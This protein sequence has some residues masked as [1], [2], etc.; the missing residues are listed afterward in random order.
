MESALRAAATVELTNAFTSVQGGLSIPPTLA[1]KMAGIAVDSL[2]VV[3][4]EAL[5][6]LGSDLIVGIAEDTEP[7]PAGVT[8]TMLRKWAQ[9]FCGEESVPEKKTST[10]KAKKKTTPKVEFASALLASESDDDDAW[11]VASMKS[12]TEADTKIGIMQAKDTEATGMS[13]PQNLAFSFS[14]HAGF[15]VGP[16]APV[17]EGSNYG[18][19]VSLTDW[20][21]KL[22]KHEHKSLKS[23]ISSNDSDGVRDHLLGLLRDYNENSMTSEATLL[24]LVHTVTEEMFTNDPK[25]KVAYYKA[26]LHKYR[27]RGLPLRDGFD[28]TLV[29]KQMKKTSEGG[30]GASA[31]EVTA[32]KT[33]LAA[34]KTTVNELKSEV[35]SLKT[36]IRELK[37]K[38]PNDGETKPCGY[39]GEVGHYARTCPKK[40]SD[41]AAKEADNAED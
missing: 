25:G 32:L 22:A 41:E 9:Y 40:K 21:R 24:T 28:L 16:D 12:M 34:L 36:S 31:T 10:S 14:L 13:P 29:V 1:R 23:Y 6:A 2:G 33:A 8:V 7:K 19:D 5:K 38:K 3:E 18:A 35:G 30:G 15:V 4:S 11:D 37:V 17:V 27:G 20:A 26:L 39:C